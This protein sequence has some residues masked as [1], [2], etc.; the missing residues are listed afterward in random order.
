MATPGRLTHP[1][2][3]EALVDLRIASTTT[4]D[5]GVLEPL[6]QE[7]RSRYPKSEPK[8]RMEARIEQQVGR[9]PTVQARVGFHGL[10]L[11]SEDDS[12]IVQFR[13]DGFTLNQ[14]AGYTTADDLFTEA[15]A[16]WRAYTHVVRP[17]A[18]IRVALRYINKLLLPFRHGDHF[19]RFLTAPVAMPA[20][21]PQH[22][23]DFLTRAVVVDG[24]TEATA[25]VAQR[26]EPATEKLTPFT[27]DI[28]VFKIGEFSV[29]PGSLEPLLQRMRELKNRLFFAL[30][31][32]EALEPYR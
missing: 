25:V 18:T 28:D 32:N 4:I 24:S 5:A 6:K 8:Q 15:L 22:V 10:F 11:K 16:L 2:I 21:A 12:R 1:P 26:L 14:V 31:T 7:F 3:Q 13:T 29:D 17:A 23:A 19:E 20:E 27:L 30:L 9:A